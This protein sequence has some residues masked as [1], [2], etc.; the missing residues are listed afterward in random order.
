MTR[1]LVTGGAGQLGHA[2]RVRA[3]P[4]GVAL[5]APPRAELDVTDGKAVAAYVAAGGFS[6][7]I[8]AAAYTAVDRAEDEPTQA[9]A[10]NAL[11]A[12]ALAEAA[13]AAEVP[14]VHVSTDY[15][16][17]GDAT[18][19]YETD[20]AIDPI[21]VYG[22]SKAAGELAVRSTCPRS[23]IV[24]TS[25]VVGARGSNFV[26]TML[27]LAADRAHVRVVADQ[28]GAPTLAA[29]LAETLA[30]VALRMIADRDAPQGVLHFANQGLTSW[31]GFAQAIFADAAA[32]GAK[33]PTL[34][35]ITSDDYPTPARRP[36]FSGLS[37]QRIEREYGIM[38]RPWREGLPALVADILK[39]GAT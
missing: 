2:L 5:I 1:I 25:W 17:G 9:F 34:E 15:V 33:V 4:Q 12:A 39:D 36:A 20:A 35:G 3:W 22:A 13:R 19:P 30:A 23:A 28:H 26:R 7:I 16:F 14:L 18:E 24:R 27:R 38:P 37:T 31:H 21:N 29:D 6:A 10:V 8:N 32:L 11:G